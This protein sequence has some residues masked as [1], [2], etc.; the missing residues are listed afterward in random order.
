[1]CYRNL[2]KYSTNIFPPSVNRAGNPLFSFRPPSISPVFL[3]IF[4]FHLTVENG[5]FN[6]LDIFSTK[7]F[8]DIFSY[9]KNSSARSSRHFCFLDS[10]DSTSFINADKISEKPLA[11]V[12][13]SI[14]KLVENIVAF[15]WN[16]NFKG[17]SFTLVN[18]TRFSHYYSP[19]HHYN[20]YLKKFR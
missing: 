10:L 8:N 11:S 19:M 13:L 18:P 1:L 5:I 16:T 14:L 7:E 17:S 2:L 3:K 9:R 20:I 15:S 4:M 12:C 6:S